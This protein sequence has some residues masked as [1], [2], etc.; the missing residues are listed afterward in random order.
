M[1][2]SLR[3]D[4][5]VDAFQLIVVE[6]QRSQVEL[7]LAVELEAAVELE[8]VVE[9]RLVVQVDVLQPGEQGVLPELLDLVEAGAED[10]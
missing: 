9:L 5:A 10:L 7:E 8:L 3:A 4:K 1:N 2:C 6:S